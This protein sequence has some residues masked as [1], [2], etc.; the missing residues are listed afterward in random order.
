MDITLWEEVPHSFCPEDILQWILHTWPLTLSTQSHFSQLSTP[1]LDSPC[2]NSCSSSIFP[3]KIS[4]NF[5][6]SLFM[7]PCFCRLSS[8]STWRHPILPSSSLFFIS[9]AYGQKWG[10]GV[11]SQK[12]VDP[13]TSILFLKRDVRVAQ[14]CLSVISTFLLSKS[15]WTSWN[16]FWCVL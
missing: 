16:G 15:N 11:T 7:L 1:S 14:V 9:A 6:S 12:L 4:M 8:M 13:H 10:G 5:F 3:S 2:L